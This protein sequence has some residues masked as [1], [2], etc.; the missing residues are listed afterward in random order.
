M[1]VSA[2]CPVWLVVGFLG[3][4]KTTLLRRLAHATGGRRLVCVVN[5]F[6]AVDVDAG[7]IEREGG[8]AIGLP[9]GSMFC[10]SMVDGFVDVFRRITEG[11]PGRDGVVF[12][13]D[14]VV[15]EASGL[16][17]PRSMRRLLVESG[18]DSAFH[19][20]GVTAVVEPGTLMKLLLVL[21]SIRGQIE[22]ADLILLNKS[23]L[24]SPDTIKKLLKKIRRINPD[25]TVIHCTQCSVDP[26]IVLADGES[27]RSAEVDVA[28]GFCGEPGYER[29]I[30]AFQ[31]A[32]D[33]REVVSAFDVGDEYLIRAKGFVQTTQGWRYVDWSAGRLSVEETPPGALS[34]LVLIWNS[35]N[36]CKV[37]ERL[38]EL[39]VKA[40]KESGKRRVISFA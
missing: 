40:G 17:D 13:P 12:Q 19:I 20:A 2:T 8:V 34:A 27:A 10:R 23:D 37:A 36:A 25:A 1:P 31:N 38:R 11:I 28:F 33:C 7:L 32:V 21:P 16:A 30:I 4:G 5:E 18:L 9:G 24:H 3:A 26:L 22:S 6:S 39:S 14:G 35:A 15:I 29:E